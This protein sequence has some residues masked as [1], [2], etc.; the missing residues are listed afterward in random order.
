[1]RSKARWVAATVGLALLLAP[2]SAEATTLQDPDD[3]GAKMLDIK[4]ASVGHTVVDGDGVLALTVESYKPFGCD[5][6]AGTMHIGRS[7]AFQIDYP[8][9]TRAPDMRI[10]VQCEAGVYLWRAR[11][12]EGQHVAQRNV[13]L[14]PTGTTLTV[15]FTQDWYGAENGELPARWKV[16]STRWITSTTAEVDTAPDSGWAEF[17]A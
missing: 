9:T 7:L 15:V 3:V 1:M 11:T 4:S 5:D 6:L 14:R 13:A 16:V 10:R 2:L 17:A 8:S 12:V